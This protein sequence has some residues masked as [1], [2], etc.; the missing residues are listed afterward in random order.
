MTNIVYEI[1]IKEAWRVSS[2]RKP[3]MDIYLKDKGGEFVKVGIGY[4]KEAK[5]IKDLVL[6]KR[7]M[8]TFT[9]FENT[10]DLLDGMNVATQ[11]ILRF[12]VKNMDSDN[13]LSNFNYREISSFTSIAIDRISNN[14]K[15]L[16]AKNV[17]KVR[18]TQTKR[19]YMINPTFYIKVNKNSVLHL[20]EKY[21]KFN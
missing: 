2:F 3:N 6:K 5:R 17:I 7:K 18:H 11:K 16:V 13:L 8:N 21:E 9:C 20:V 1:L 4:D 14:I 15:I 12:F 19:E 10:L